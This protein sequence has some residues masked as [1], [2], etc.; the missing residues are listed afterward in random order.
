MTFASAQ[1]YLRD[2]ETMRGMPVCGNR[3]DVENWN[4]KININKEI[5]LGIY[6]FSLYIC[7]SCSIDCYDCIIYNNYCN[8]M[9]KK[10]S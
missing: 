4:V 5:Y 10:F 6:L 1:L 7:L 8:N 3:S 9:E 2:I